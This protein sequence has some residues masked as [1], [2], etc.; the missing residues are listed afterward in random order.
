[1]KYEHIKEKKQADLNFYCCNRDENLTPGVRYGPVIRDSYIIE[2]CTDGYGSVIIN[3]KEFMIRPGDCIIL[4]PG[5]T[6]IHT[7]DYVN[8]REGVWC[9]VGGIKIA[10]YLKRAEITSEQ[11]FAPSEAFKGIVEQIENM[12][13]IDNDTDPGAEL[14]R[15]GY[16][17]LLFG[18]I[19]RHTKKENDG[20]LYIQKAISFMEMNYILPLTIPEIANEIGLERCYFSTLFKNRLGKTPHAFLTETRIKKA[21]ML[22]ESSDMQISEIAEAVG[23]EPV[24]FSRVFKKYTGKQPGE[25][26]KRV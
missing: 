22:L 4:F 14:R 7:A 11:P 26:K 17:H 13:E 25:Y 18:E 23:I 1:M 16:I 8:P 5:D 21:C 2:C 19:L 20:G 10:S 15:N 12:L 24:N 6:I 3:G 9:S